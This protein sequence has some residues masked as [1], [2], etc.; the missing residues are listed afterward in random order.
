MKVAVIGSRKLENIDAAYNI[1]TESIPKNCSE[2]VSGGAAGI[3]KLAERY[4]AE[5]NLHLTV[6]LPEYDKYGRVAT[7]IR[8]TQIVKYAD[9]IYAF[10][11][12]KSEGTRK[13]IL[14]CAELEKPFKIFKL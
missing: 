14:K 9:I 2:I 6:F 11:D 13:T 3:D 1:I 5:N 10:W 7:L 12:M 8:N 4:A